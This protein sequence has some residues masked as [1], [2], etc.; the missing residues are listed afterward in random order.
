MQVKPCGQRLLVLLEQTD[1]FVGE[2]KIIVAP[3]TAKK[4]L[5]FGIVL[6]LGDG[7]DKTG[8]VRQFPAKVGD[9]VMVSKF[10]GIEV[11]ITGKSLKMYDAGDI[12]A[13]IEYDKADVS[14]LAKLSGKPEV[15]DAAATVK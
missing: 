6:A 1:E 5:Q 15:I 12:L 14:A 8:E 10:G 2:S 7:R 4:E 11:K 9:K 13:V 3:E